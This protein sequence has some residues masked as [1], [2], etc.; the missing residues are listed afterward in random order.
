MT[1]KVELL[2]SLS[3]THSTCQVKHE[4]SKVLEELRYVSSLL[5]LTSVV[6]MV[7]TLQISGLFNSFVVVE[8]ESGGRRVAQNSLN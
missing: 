5:V 1:E 4:L 8:E 7:M 6:V 2:H 3:V